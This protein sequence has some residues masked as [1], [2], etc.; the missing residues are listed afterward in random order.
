MVLM[1]DLS[2]PLSVE[3]RRKFKK[4]ENGNWKK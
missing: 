3:N 4:S 2:T 1:I